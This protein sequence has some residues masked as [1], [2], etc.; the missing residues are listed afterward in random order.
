[1]NRKM[2]SLDLGTT[3]VKAGLFTENGE[4]LATALE[5]YQL[6]TPFANE[7]E[8][9]AEIYW[10]ASVKT[11][12]TVIEKVNAD[13]TQICGI[14]IS[15]QGETLI[16]VDKDGKPLRNAIVWIDNRA[17]K[18]A[19]IL[20]NALH[21]VYEVTGIPDVLPT[22]PG[23]KIMWIRKH[24]PDFFS[25]TFK[26]LFVQDFIVYRLCGKFVTNP[27]IC[28]TSLYFDITKDGWWNDAL[29][30]IGIKENVLPIITPSGTVVGET[31]DEVNAMLG[32]SQ[33]IAVI[34]G[35]M[36]QSVCAIG[37][38]TITGGI[39]SETTGSALCIQM[40]ADRPD[41]DTQKLIPVYSH[42]IPGKYLFV[43]VCP[44][45]GMSYKWF[46]DNFASEEIENANL[47][48]KD[49]YEVLNGMAASVPAG[50]D[51][52]RML[53]HL[54]G[55]FC[56]FSNPSARG[57]FTGFTLHHT[58]SHFI[59]AILESVAY[60]LRRNLEV[61]IQNGAEFSEVRATGGGAKSPLWNQIKANVCNLPVVTLQ[62]EDT[63]LIGDAILVG[64]ATGIYKDVSEGCEK[65]VHIRSKI[66]P[67]QDVEIYNREYDN[68]CLL[69]DTLGAYFRNLKQ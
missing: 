38:G 54:M 43:P 66:L 18:E 25:R 60:L 30:A 47:S 6:L 67:D 63:G 23:C 36:D 2:L 40:V 56:P 7:A 17:E 68:Y 69:D 64:L 13:A 35:G 4:M 55:A 48:G 46:R 8:L 53:P 3:S 24:E 45:A 33:P 37:A 44:T 32:L 22:W 41:L 20:K 62:T 57:S 58:K 51:G 11:I 1:M 14:A 49:I 65:F 61:M 59:R 27:S 9:D 42:S 10:N 12:R 15:S 34:G 26:F 19:E 29:D 16:A 52:L 50:S 39:V 28:C 31:T 21:N 5:E